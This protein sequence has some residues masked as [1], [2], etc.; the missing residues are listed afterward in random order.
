MKS[1]VA[2]L[3]L[4]VGVC[5]VQ[6]SEAWFGWGWGGLGWGGLGWGWPWGFGYR[7]FRSTMSQGELANRTQCVFIRENSMINCKGPVGIF[8]CEAT[9]NFTGLGAHKFELYGIGAR[10]ERE[11]EVERNEIES[12]FER[13]FL[14][15]RK[16]DNS[17]WFNHTMKVDDREVTVAIYNSFKFNFFGFRVKEERCFERLVDIFNSTTSFETVK[18]EPNMQEVRL[19]GEIMIVDKPIQPK[20]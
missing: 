13:Y 7:W 6:Q 9:A 19:L 12:E 5:L 2:L 18:V 11:P 16:L 4:V 1:V 20:V 15:P 14:Y 10:V 8:E 17:G 3:V